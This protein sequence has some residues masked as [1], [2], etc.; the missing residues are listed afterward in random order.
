MNNIEEI[1]AMIEAGASREEVSKFV[2]QL[3]NDEK[4]NRKKTKMKRA[5]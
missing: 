3:P 1:D 5:K 4:Q 2:D